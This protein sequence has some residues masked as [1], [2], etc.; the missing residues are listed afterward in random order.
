WRLLQR[1]NDTV[2][3]ATEVD[4]K[5][6]T[7]LAGSCGGCHISCCCEGYNGACWLLRRLPYRLQRSSMAYAEAAIKAVGFY[8]GCHIAEK[9][10]TLLKRLYRGYV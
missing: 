3:A 5:A 4:V 2:K 1:L 10:A 8:K 6:T 7:E 9:A